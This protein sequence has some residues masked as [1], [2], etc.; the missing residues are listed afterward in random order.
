MIDENEDVKKFDPY[1][2]LERIRKNIELHSDI[3][4]K[5]LG[6]FIGNEVSYEC[7][8]GSCRGWA[9][10]KTSYVAVQYAEMAAETE[11]SPHT[12]NGNEE[13]LIVIEGEL[14][15]QTEGDVISAKA[16][17]CIHVGAG[18]THVAYCII[19]TAVIGVTV[20]ASEGYPD[21]R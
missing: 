16:G 10:K 20:P 8:R 18:Q 2:N 19:P 3:P 17:G 5:S 12:H 13:Y 14:F 4:L 7:V 6:T 11:M 21:E 9:L 15:S 1:E